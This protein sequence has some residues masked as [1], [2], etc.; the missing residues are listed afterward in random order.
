MHGEAGI[1][2]FVHGNKDKLIRSEEYRAMRKCATIEE[3]K[4]K[5]QPTIYGKALLEETSMT[6]KTFKQVMYKCLEKQIQLTLA[7]STPVSKQ[8]VN[9]YRESY[10]ISNFIYLWACKK[11]GKKSLENA[12]NIH[13]IGNYDGLS[14]IK[15]TQSAED[16]WKF[17]IENTPL[18]K[19]TNGLKSSILL[20]DTQ[21]ITNILQK[22]YL[23]LLYDFSV[24]NNLC[25][26]EVVQF[27]GDKK[28]IEILYSTVDSNIPAK[29]KL[30]LFPLC[31]TF[32]PEQKR[33]LIRC[34]TTDEIRGMLSTHRIYINVVSSE[35]SIEDALQRE[36]ITLCKRSFYYYDDPSIV[37]TQLKL[38]EIEISTLVFLA[39]C[40]L[41][42]RTEHLQEI[43]N[44]EDE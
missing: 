35:V 11:E 32:T 26:S 37:Y 38:Q 28:I 21:Y 34:K 20:E 4:V 36:E 17:C 29:D 43:I 25:L 13:P 22:K 14:F 15:A 5:M 40:I 2:S 3:L 7:F 30:S 1:I 23:E 9:F 8:L 12:K 44:L 41:H 42:K 31:S 6:P 16:T 24:Q 33:K 10:Q 19:Y 27:E 39:E 18:K